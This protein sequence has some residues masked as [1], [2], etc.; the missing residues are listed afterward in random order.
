MELKVCDQILNYDQPVVLEDIVKACNGQNVLAATIDGRLREL[1]YVV[2]KDSEINFIGYESPDAIHM[3]EATL[4]YIVAMAVHRVF[5]QAKIHFNYSISRSILAIF[6]GLK[7]ALNQQKLDELKKE[8]DY[9]IQSD[10]PIKRRRI[11]VGEALQLYK[12][13]N[14]DDKVDIIKYREEEYVNLYECEGYMN[15]MFGYMLPSTGYIQDYAFRL[16]HPGFL[17]HYPRAELNG[18]I[19]PFND[20]PT[21]GRAL[22]D[23]ARWGQ[24]ISGNTIPRMNEWAKD[25]EKVVEFVNMCETKHFHMLSDLGDMIASNADSLRLIA[26]AGPSSSGKTTFAKRLRVELMTRGIHPIRISIDDYYL[27]IDKAPLDHENK[28]DLEHIEALDLELFNHDMLALIQGEAVTLPH[29]NFQTG[30]RQTGKK[31]Q[32]KADTPI[33]IEGIHALNERLTASIP[34]H[35]KFKIYISP[36]TQLHIDDHNPI[37]ITELRLLRRIVRDQQFRGTSAM[38]TMAM[39]QSVRRGEFKWIYPFQKEADYVFNSELS[40]ELAVLKKYAIQQLRAIPTESEYFI[41]ANRLLKF[42]KY[43]VD[44]DDKSVPINSLIREF[45]G[46]SCFE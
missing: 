7:G 37:S 35:Q 42:L 20:E 24:I 31:I 5:G 22:K 15:Y 33:I 23:S 27:G 36:Q 25:K 9:I 29:F 13:F 39:W 43:F 45:I 1:T 41:T 14:M 28:P 34:K 16:Y 44:I 30:K 2:T 10:F 11:S 38:D 17:I 6:E 4:R 26:I 32:L 19:P 3:Y 40:Y 18:K 46:G 21:F 8:V 12:S